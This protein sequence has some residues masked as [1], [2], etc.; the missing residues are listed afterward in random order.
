MEY[1]LDI[2]QVL[3]F[4]DRLNPDGR[5]LA[6]TIPD[7]DG[8]PGWAV[9]EA[10]R[11]SNVHVAR[12][13]NRKV[14]Y[15]SMLVPTTWNFPTA[16]LALRGAPWQLAEFILRGYDPCVSCAS[17][18]IVINEDGHVVVDKNMVCSPERSVRSG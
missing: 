9:N 7:G 13:K 12:V 17:H 11:G 1:T 15:F 4:I 10:P 18:M 6:D 16:G 5:V 14:Q 3:D 2:Y 8:S